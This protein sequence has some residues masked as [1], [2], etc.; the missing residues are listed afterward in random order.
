VAVTTC[1]KQIY[2]A[3][4]VDEKFFRRLADLV[5]SHQANPVFAV[6]LSDDSSIDGLTVD[7]LVELHNT[8]FRAIV[9]ADLV[10]DHTSNLKVR[11]RLRGKFAETTCS[12]EVVGNEKDATYIALEID[13]LIKD[14]VRPL[15]YPSSIPPVHAGAW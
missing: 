2:K 7:E 11:V 4:V 8:R 6:T 15:S 14:A 3:L 10:P 5:Q 1:S 12:Y 9:D 13:R